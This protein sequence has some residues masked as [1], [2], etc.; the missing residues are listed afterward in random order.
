MTEQNFY[1]QA[2]E[3][4]QGNEA[5]ITSPAS[6]RPAQEQAKTQEFVTPQELTERLAEFER[7]VQSSTD[8]AVSSVN[9]KVADAQ[10]KANN[11]IQMLKGSG[12]QLSPEQEASIRRKAIDDAYLEVPQSVQ[13]PTPKGQEQSPQQP[14]DNVANFVNSEIQK[15]VDREQVM[16]SPE[17]MQPY[18]NLPPYEFIKKAED[19]VAQ[20]KQ[21]RATSAVPSL[22]PNGQP[23]GSQ[24][25]LRKAYELERAQIYQGTHP[26]IKRGNTDAFFA[27]LNRYQ[28]QGMQGPP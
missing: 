23:T 1:N 9:K 16:L 12:L 2:V 13:D 8:K 21:S 3:A 4:P 24:E 10:E 7:R 20:K 19:L 26:T 11:A 28:Q 5:P 25:E 6:P 27:M 22:A 17:E 14:Q 15:I 18:A